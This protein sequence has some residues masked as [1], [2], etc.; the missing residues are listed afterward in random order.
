MALG[1]FIACFTDKLRPFFLTLKV[2]S[3]FGWINE[4]KHA[5]KV[6]KC[7]LTESPILSSPKFDEEL[8]IYLVIF[9]YAVITVL[10]RHI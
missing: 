1:S 3:M 4:Y 9:D 10:F 8:Y 5:F 2:A 6:V 7:Y